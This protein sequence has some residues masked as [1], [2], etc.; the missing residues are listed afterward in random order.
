[1]TVKISNSVLEDS[2]LQALLSSIFCRR[3]LRQNL[4]RQSS[5]R[6]LGAL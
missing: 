6:T 4:A 5:N 2:C 1:M 3:K